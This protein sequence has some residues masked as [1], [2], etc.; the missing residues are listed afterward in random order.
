M[1]AGEQIFDWAG[2]VG[3]IVA[4]ISALGAVVYGAIRARSDWRSDDRAEAS[5][6]DA[7]V[8]RLIK[9]KDE[10]IV[11]LQDD[12]KELRDQLKA[13]LAREGAMSARVQELER[14]LAEVEREARLTMG[15]VLEAIARSDRCENAPSCPNRRPPGADRQGDV[16]VVAG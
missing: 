11:A 8:D 15:N 6:E 16:A 9:L 2:H 1:T 3:G 12:R 13:S 14:R 7:E 10:M 4:G 5:A